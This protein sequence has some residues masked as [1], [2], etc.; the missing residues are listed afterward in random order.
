MDWEVKHIYDFSNPVRG[1]SPR[2]AGSPL[3]FNGNYIPWLTVAALTN[4]SAS[5]LYVKE[6]ESFLTR[7]GSE[8]SRML[9]SNTLIIAN[10][11]ATLGVAKLLSMKCCANDGIAALINFSNHVDKL[12]VVYYLNSIT[13][14]L[15]EVIATGNGQPNLNTDLIGKLKIPLPPTKSEQTA[16]ATALSDTDALIENLE[17]LIGKKRNIKQGVMQELLKSKEGWSTKKLGDFLMYEQP[18]KYLVKYTEYNNNNQTPVLTAGKTFILGYTDEE[19]GIYDNIPVI[20][21]DDFTTANKFVTFT[22]KAKSSAMKMLTGKNKEV[23]LR[24][25]Y[26]IMQTIHYPLSDHKRYWISE[27]QHIEIKV[28]SPEEQKSIS[29]ILGNMDSEIEQ[30]ENKLHKYRMIKQGMMQ[31]LLTGKIR[32]V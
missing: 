25:M 20:I 3:Y 4:I 27:Y 21:F 23:N 10:S 32:L 31:V 29:E 9:E 5:Q 26:E 18:T 15:R 13:K 16:I 2:P 17:K 6:T 7:E 14:R 8:R 24:F 11:G 28:P 30:F 1:G 22:F 12:Y 19:F